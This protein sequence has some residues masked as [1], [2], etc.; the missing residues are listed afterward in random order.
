MCAFHYPAPFDNFESSFS[1]VLPGDLQH[2]VAMLFD[3]CRQAAY[4][5]GVITQSLRH[6][7]K[8]ALLQLSQQF[9]RSITIH[10]SSAGDH[11][12]YDQTHSLREEMPLSSVDFLMRVNST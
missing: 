10:D 12:G 3:P 5:V 6:S 9:P 8:L 1:R 11:H 4:A 2:I 7:W